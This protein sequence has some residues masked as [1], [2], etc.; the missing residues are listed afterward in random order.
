MDT[1]TEFTAVKGARKYRQRT[2]DEKRQIVEETL[3]SGRS[4]ALTRG[5]ALGKRLVWRCGVDCNGGSRRDPL[6]LEQLCRDRT[7]FDRYGDD[8]IR[9]CHCQRDDCGMRGGD[10]SHCNDCS[11]IDARSVAVATPLWC[12]FQN[13]FL[14]N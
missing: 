12:K 10:H 1:L 4:V 8:A 9:L 2:V 5:V 6:R 13:P 11:S 3:S 14:K 7:R